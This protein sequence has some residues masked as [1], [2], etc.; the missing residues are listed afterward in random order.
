MRFN[1]PC[2][3]FYSAVSAVSKVI[4]PKNALAIL[5]NFLLELKD[6]IL[7]VTGADVDNSL[8]ARIAVTDHDGECKFCVTARRLVDLLKE[9]PDQGVTVTVNESTFE[10]EIEYTGGKYNLT[11][12]DGNEYPVYTD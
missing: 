10:V 6:G 9:L 2:K 5:D 7:T 11:A 4:N 12:I 8:T 1:V 3:A